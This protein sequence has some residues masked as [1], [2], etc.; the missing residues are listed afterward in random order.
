MK[1]KTTLLPSVLRKLEL[2]GEQIKLARLRRR[3]S[4]KQVCERAG[5]SR[6]TLGKVENGNSGVSIGTYAQVLFVLKLENDIL[7]W[8]ED[9]VL[10]RRLQ[11][12]GLVTKQRAPKRAKS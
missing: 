8:A 5:I 1:K 12:A 11:D 6:S 3:L 9:D 4:M 7:K 10:G 2:L